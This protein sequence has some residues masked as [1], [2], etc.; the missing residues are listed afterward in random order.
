MSRKLKLFEERKREQLMWNFF[1]F[2][3]REFLSGDISMP[4]NLSFFG[5]NIYVYMSNENKHKIRVYL[6]ET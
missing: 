3:Q 6:K 2:V 4:D 5:C 1:F